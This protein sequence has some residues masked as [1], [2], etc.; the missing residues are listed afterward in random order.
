MRLTSHT[1]AHPHMCDTARQGNSKA[2]LSASLPWSGT[3]IF[4]RSAQLPQPHDDR[5][6]QGHAYSNEMDILLNITMFTNLKQEA[7]KISPIQYCA[8]A[9]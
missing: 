2:V 1:V 7:V 8:K 6:Q 4:A 9:K 3:L 5:H